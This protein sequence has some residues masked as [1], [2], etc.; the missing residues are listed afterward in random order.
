MFLDPYG[1]DVRVQQ[2]ERLRPA[3]WKYDR[4]VGEHERRGLE[5]S[6]QELGRLSRHQHPLQPSEEEIANNPP[7]R[8]A[9]LRG[10]EMV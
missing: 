6:G 4:G 5:R 3:E 7:S 9:K 2:S 8:S 1:V 10:L